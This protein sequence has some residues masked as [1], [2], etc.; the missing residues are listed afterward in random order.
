[1]LGNL[2]R[3]RTSWDPGRAADRSDPRRHQSP[4]D[5]A[6][7]APC[8]IPYLDTKGNDGGLPR[9]VILT[10]RPSHRRRPVPDHRW[11]R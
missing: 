9:E 5:R 7:L 4:D 2:L 6:D 8:E 11:L 1:M 10:V 3:L